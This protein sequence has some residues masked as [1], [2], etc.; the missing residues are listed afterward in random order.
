MSFQFK[1]LAR[2]PAE[3]VQEYWHGIHHTNHFT[4][5]RS[6]HARRPVTVSITRDDNGAFV[7]MS[8]NGRPASYV[9]GSEATNYFGMEGIC[10]DFYEDDDSHVGTS[11]FDWNLWWNKKLRIAPMRNQ[12]SEDR[13]TVPACGSFLRLRA[14][15]SAR[16]PSWSDEKTNLNKSRHRRQGPPRNFPLFH[17]VGMHQNSV[18]L[19]RS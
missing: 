6:P 16:H 12:Y 18:S 10:R 8:L 13:Q 1:I 15:I 14:T 4:A 9:M 19:H 7:I 11:E 17:A 3:N 2:W 5:Q